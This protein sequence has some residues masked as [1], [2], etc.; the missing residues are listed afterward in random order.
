[1]TLTLK[2]KE[3]ILNLCPEI[4]REDVVTIRFLSKLNK[5]LHTFGI[6]PSPLYS[7]SNL[8]DE[9]PYQMFLDSA[10]NDSIFENSKVLSNHILL[11]FKLFVYKSREKSS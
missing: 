7:F 4:L 5:N 2:K 1:M 10:N 11:I 6:K 9:T 3:K 8:Y